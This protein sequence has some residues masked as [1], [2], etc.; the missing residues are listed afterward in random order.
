MLQLDLAAAGVPYAVASP[1][2][3]PLCA[4]FHALR[5][6]YITYLADAGVSQRHAQ[7]SARHS[8]PRLTANVYTHV[9]AAALAESVNRLALPASG[10]DAGN[11]LAAL[12]RE[13]L[14][15]L[16]GVLLATVG[17]LLAPP[18]APTSDTVRD[19]R[20]R[21]GTGKADSERAA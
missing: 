4:D 17:A 19:G 12:S 14:E 3:T 5:H 15:G 13:Q 1:D 6:T 10:Q 21:A 2:G 11:P 16:C 9:R 8:D 18:L 7:E 20:G